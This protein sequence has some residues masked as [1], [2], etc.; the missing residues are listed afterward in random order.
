VGNTKFP[1]KPKF[2]EII[3]IKVDTYAGSAD[4]ASSIIII[5]VL[6]VKHEEIKKK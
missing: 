4:N 1:V 5:M 6:E 2:T 3:V